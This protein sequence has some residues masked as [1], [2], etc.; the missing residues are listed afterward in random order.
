MNEQQ[1]FPDHVGPPLSPGAPHY[2]RAGVSRSLNELWVVRQTLGLALE[3]SA[4][5]IELNHLRL[6]QETGC[7][8]L[9]GPL[10]GLMHIH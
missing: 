8:N 9:T 3:A 5:N 10:S 6:L 1:R 2:R 7:A 4:Q